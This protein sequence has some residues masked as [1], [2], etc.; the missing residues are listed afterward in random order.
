MK[1]SI[2][3]I[4]L[5]LVLLQTGCGKEKTEQKAV[6]LSEDVIP[7]KLTKVETVVRAEPVR[8]SGTVASLEEARLSFKIGGM[9]SRVFVKEGQMVRKGQLLAILDQ[10]E[11]DAQVSQARYASEKSERDVQRVKNMVKD[12]AA[13]LEQLQNATTGFD[14]AQQNLKIASFNQS[15]SRIISPLDGTVSKKFIN[16][17]ELT[18]PGTPAIL[19]TSTRKNDWVIRA[20]ISDKDW[21]RIKQGDKA[22]LKLDAYPEVNFQGRVTNMAQTADPV[23]KLY[24]IE[25]KIEPAGNRLASGLYAKVD[26]TP[27]QSRSYSLVPVEAVVEGN[28]S[29]GFVYINDNG[30]AKRVA[31]TVGYLDGN[32]VLISGGLEGVSEVITTGSGFLTENARIGVEN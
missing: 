4:L 23:S 26:L 20:G 8:V 7:V 5:A 18:G 29:E 11:I 16:E 25:I 28:G 2:L 17:G 27:S 24:E 13:T 12:T 15:Y 31:V 21:V 30:K 19:V 14:V 1:P 10:T 6:D 9:I 22:V 3:I 32:K